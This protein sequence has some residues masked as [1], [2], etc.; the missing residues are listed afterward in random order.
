[1]PVHFDERRLTDSRGNHISVVMVMAIVYVLPRL[2]LGD[3]RF[4]GFRVDGR[5][6]RVDGR[7]RRDRR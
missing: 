5:V 6:Q 3:L 4:H 2:Y 7:R 1:M